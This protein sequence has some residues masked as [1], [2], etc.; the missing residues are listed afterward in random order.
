MIKLRLEPGHDP[1]MCRPFGPRGHA[2]RGSR[3]RSG[4]D[5]A[6]RGLLVVYATQVVSPIFHLFD[7]LSV[8]MKPF[9]LVSEIIWLTA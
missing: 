4:P 7:D 1:N 8:P 9:G 5:R 3:N 2:V 6:H